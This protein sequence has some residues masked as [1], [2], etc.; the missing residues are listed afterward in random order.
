MIRILLLS[1]LVSPCVYG[2]E[3]DVKVSKKA[4]SES[5]EKIRK[6]QKLSPTE[7]VTIRAKGLLILDVKKTR[8]L[9]LEEGTY[10]L[11]PHIAKLEKLYATHKE[12]TAYLVKRDLWNCTFPYKAMAV[13]GSSKPYIVDRIKI[14]KSGISKSGNAQVLNLSWSN[15]DKQY[16]GKHYIIL[17]QTYGRE[18]ILDVIP[19]ANNFGNINLSNYDEEYLQYRVV[20]EDCRS[21]EQK[22]I[23]N[24]A[25]GNLDTRSTH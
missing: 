23:R 15:P 8:L 20:A 21:T 22:K 12:F 1:L 18:F 25:F 9:R 5:G 2:Q 19:C 11:E 14:T 10:E 24:V 16:K 6:G 7:K 3:F 17:Q 13:P 4:Y